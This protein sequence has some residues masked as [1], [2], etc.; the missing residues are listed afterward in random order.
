MLRAEMQKEATMDD[1][2]VWA[3]RVILPGQAPGN[4]TG[5]T[6]DFWLKQEAALFPP[7]QA[8]NLIPNE[9]GNAWHGC[10][11]GWAINPACDPNSK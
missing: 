1:A 5:P 3:P 4:K 7:F 9:G 11:G 2:F 8:R 6:E 10:S